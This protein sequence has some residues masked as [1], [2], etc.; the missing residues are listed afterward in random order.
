M[1][2]S[3]WNKYK[4]TCCY[5]D[6]CLTPLS[7]PPP[8]HTHPCYRPP[9]CCYCY[10]SLCCYSSSS[11]WYNCPGWL[12][13]KKHMLFAALSHCCCYSARS[14]SSV[15]SVLSNANIHLHHNETNCYRK[16]EHTLFLQ[17]SII[18]DHKIHCISLVQHF[19][20]FNC[21]CIN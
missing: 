6:R 15:T 13:V 7:P 18:C 8:T 1:C 12:G 3:N 16:T 5:Y 17:I 21:T 9:C 19:D 11:L 10:R 2:P 14:Q 20:M 4:F